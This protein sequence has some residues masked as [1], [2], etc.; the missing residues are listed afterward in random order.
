MTGMHRLCRAITRQPDRRRGAGQGSMCECESDRDGHDRDAR[1]KRADAMS[2][3]SMTTAH[4]SS[5]SAPA[6]RAI[7]RS[8][9]V[10][11]RHR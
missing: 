6:S 8:R 11:A 4:A 9:C 7:D 3:L 10:R 2:P 1:S 5:R